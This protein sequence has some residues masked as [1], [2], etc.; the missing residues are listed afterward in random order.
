MIKYILKCEKEHEF[1]SWFLNSKEFE[2]LKTKGKLSPNDNIKWE[3]KFEKLRGNIT[4][5]EKRLNKL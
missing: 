2:R 3:K 5:A 4:K 1:E